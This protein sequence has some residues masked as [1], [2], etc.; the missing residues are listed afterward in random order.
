VVARIAIAHLKE[1]PAMF[2]T[3]FVPALAVALA[4]IGFALAPAA[5][6][7]DMGKGMS[8][9]KMEK[10][11]AMKPSGKSD[12]MKKD[13]MKKKTDAMSNGMNGMDKK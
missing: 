10:S 12:G 9:D 2:R 1:T 3:R 8:K 13:T 6:A 5:F 4:S 11:S 7:D